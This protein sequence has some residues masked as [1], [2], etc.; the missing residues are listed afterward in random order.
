MPIGTSKVGVLGA[1]TV[2]GGS[3]TFNSSG[4]FCVPSGVTSVNVTGT[5]GAGNPGNAGNPGGTGI[6][7]GGGSRPAT[8][9][10]SART[11]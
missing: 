7:G 1:G 8:P 5:G 9:V 6:G 10:K 3:E 2:P 4:T 11:L